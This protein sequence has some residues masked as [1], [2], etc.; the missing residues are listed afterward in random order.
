MS[1]AFTATDPLIT[2]AAAL[3]RAS[4]LAPLVRQRL[5]ALLPLCSSIGFPGLANR[6]TGKTLFDLATIAE[7]GDLCDVIETAVVRGTR[8]RTDW[9]AVRCIDGYE[10][11]EEI[12][13]LERTPTGEA[14]AA[15]AAELRAV[16][17]LAAQ[18]HAL[19]A[20]AQILGCNR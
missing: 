12:A 6:L 10:E 9:I 18:T 16:I 20:A 4:A 17:D 14:L 1:D 15:I 19:L 7:L 13:R 2:A 5:P 11:F 3:R 8:R